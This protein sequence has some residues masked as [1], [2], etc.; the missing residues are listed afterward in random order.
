MA[1]KFDQDNDQ[2][3]EIN[4]SIDQAQLSEF[5]STLKWSQNDVIRQFLTTLQAR[6]DAVNT[7]AMQLRMEREDAAFRQGSVQWVSIG[8]SGP[9][10]EIIKHNEGVDTI[11]AWINKFLT[12]RQEFLRSFAWKYM[13][14]DL[15]AMYDRS[16]M[17][18]QNKLPRVS[19]PQVGGNFALPTEG[20]HGVLRVEDNEKA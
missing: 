20:Q 8:P 3:F 9:S 19:R 4:A 10:Q 18:E 5:A 13:P 7:R 15:R 16:Q 14:K 6:V 12:D 1:T 17:L 11:I 2:I